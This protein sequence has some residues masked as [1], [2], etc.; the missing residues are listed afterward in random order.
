MSVHAEA[1]APH[2]ILGVIVN[3]RTGSPPIAEAVFCRRL[4]QSGRRYG[5]TVLIFTADGIE[6][7]HGS[8]SGYIYR[9]K[10]WIRSRITLPDLIYDRQ[11]GSER[12]AS[13]RLGLQRLA[14]QTARPLRYWSRGLPGKWHVYKKLATDYQLRSVLPPTLPYYGGRLLRDK[15]QQQP[16]LFLKPQ[17][18][19]HGKGVLAVVSSPDG[20]YLSVAGRNHRNQSFRLRFQN[21][22]TA[23]DWVD[24][25]IAGQRYIVQ[26]FLDLR[27]RGG[28]PF[29]VRALVQK[30]LAG[31]WTLTGLVVREGNNPE[32]LTSNLHGGGSA[33]Q[34]LAYLEEL[35]G[36]EMAAI[37]VQRLEMLALKLPSLIEAHYG[38]LGEL[39]IDF[40]VD[41]SRRIWLLEVNSRPGRSAFFGLEDLT[42]AR[43]SIYRPLQYARY[44]IG[45]HD[46]QDRMTASHSPEAHFQ[47]NSPAD[48]AAALPRG[49]YRLSG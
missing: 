26:P 3:R 16:R 2:R 11:S 17:A 45:K 29:D 33:H 41:T 22:D 23:I 48:P 1:A 15:L 18:G 21:L 20:K 40:G 25:Y 19:T 28:R 34:A 30:N 4:C 32:G 5:L 37:L 35:F 13:S 49:P 43:Q 24:E 7:Q 8:I 14:E 12:R 31:I 38:S 36:Q 39:G 42:S 47:V 6:P 44:L 9:G 10:R 27:G 46:R